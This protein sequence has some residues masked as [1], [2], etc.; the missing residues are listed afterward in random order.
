MRSLMKK[1]PQG[2]VVNY[3][4]HCGDTF[5]HQ[6]HVE[7]LTYRFAK[8][9]EAEQA[10]AVRL[11]A[12]AIVP[13]W[14]QVSAPIGKIGRRQF[15]VTTHQQVIRQVETADCSRNVNAE[16]GSIEA[17]A[18]SVPAMG[19][20]LAHGR[21]YQFLDFPYGFFVG[22]RLFAQVSE[23]IRPQDAIS[24]LECLEFFPRGIKIPKNIFF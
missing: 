11:Q 18:R 17:A 6:V 13:E 15:G 21:Q 7:I 23:I 12:A 16:F 5:V 19:T 20:M 22:S 4:L 2:K 1:S 10:A 14:T 3:G 8:K 24:K 9:M